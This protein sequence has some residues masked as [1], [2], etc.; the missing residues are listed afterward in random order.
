[1]KITNNFLD[2]A[3]WAVVSKIIAGGTAFL[4]VFILGKTLGATNYG[5]FALTLSIITFARIIGGSGLGQSTGKHLAN[6]ENAEVGAKTGSY[7]AAGFLAQTIVV[8]LL[9]MLLWFNSETI[10]SYFS[11]TK[12][13]GPSLK[14]GAVI[15]IFFALTEFAKACLQG[16]QRFDYLALVTGIEF[17]GKLL[18]A[19][20]L[21][22]IGYGVVG[23]LEG[24]AFALAL[25]T[26]AAVVL[27][28]R[29]GLSRP[30]LN[31]AEWR[32]LIGYSLPLILTGVGFTIYTELDNIM[33]GYYI[34]IKSAGIYSLAINMARAIPFFAS[35]IGLAAAPVVVRLSQKEES[36]AADFV[37]RLIKYIMAGAFPAAT[38]LYVLA[39]KLLA[40]VGEDYVA[41]A[42]ALR[43]MSVFVL[44]LSIA[45]VTVPILDYLGK[46]WMRAAWMVVSVSANVLLNFLLIPRFGAAGA[47]LATAV[48]HTPFTLNNVSVLARAVGLK[49]KAIFLAVGQIFAASAAA[50]AVAALALFWLD[51]II[52]AV[53]SGTLLYISLLLLMGIFSLAEIGM[54]VQKILLSIKGPVSN[55]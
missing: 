26:L 49:P 11:D 19:G 9:S 40:M 35:P 22:L 10:A 44:S 24:Y 53:L 48:T 55:E 23:A 6:L 31:P 25:A 14:I 39:P 46:A 32:S 18:F 2:N 17:G 34:G 1:M 45:T 29:L 15:M 33:I 4:L 51:S 5:V 47:A 27:L 37:G 54:I 41:G 43:V 42:P 36:E 3:R 50:G 13:F 38:A 7:L 21:A 52:A 20:G 30:S 16:P 8:I 12:Q 28:L